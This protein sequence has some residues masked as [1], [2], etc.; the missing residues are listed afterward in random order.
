MKRLVLMA[1]ASGLAACGADPVPMATPAETIAGQQFAAPPD[2][3][4]A[5]YIYCKKGDC[6]TMVAGMDR[7]T[8][9][10]LQGNM[11]LRVDVK[12]GPHDIRC[13]T[14]VLKDPGGILPVDLKPDETVFVAMSVHPLNTPS[15]RLK[16]ESAE[17]AKPIVLSGQRVHEMR[18]N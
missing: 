4:S 8:L 16:L 13:N 7:D 5:L 11:W 17:V 15:C 12:P 6:I 2:G 18:G 10:L 14:Q 3:R 9:A 1:A